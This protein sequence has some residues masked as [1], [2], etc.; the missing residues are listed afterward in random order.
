MSKVNLIA[1]ATALDLTT[2]GPQPGIKLSKTP[3]LGGQGWS[4]TLENQAAIGGAGVVLVQAHDQVGGSVPIAGDAGWY[5]IATLNAAAPL[6]QE[7]ELPNFIRL[8]KSVA[9]T[10]TATINLYAVQ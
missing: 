7:I 6:M 10:G 1:L 5:T 9:G 8:N 4:A 3:F 2:T